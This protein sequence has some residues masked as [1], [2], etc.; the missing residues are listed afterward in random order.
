METRPTHRIGIMQGRL[1]P[2]VGDRV[3][4]FPGPLWPTEFTLAAELGYEAMELTI[5]N[6]SLET[7]PLLSPQGRRQIRDTAA[8]A[9]IHLAG[10]CCDTV[11]E[12]PLIGPD[13]HKRA[14]ALETTMALIRASAEAGLPMVELPMMGENSLRH[15][16]AYDR[17]A[18]VLDHLLPLADQLGILI[19][20]E[21]DVPPADIR[22]FLERVDHPRFGINYDSGNSTWFGY[23]PEDEIPVYAHW[24]G[25]VHVKDCTRKDYSVPLGSGETRLDD[26]FRLLLT[27]GYA[28]DFIL[29]AA[30]QADDVAAA[31][32]YLTV[33]RQTLTNARNS[34]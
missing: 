11:M 24:I 28:G 20:L 14:S 1:L 17:M 13:E 3:Q 22:R 6:A 16:G 32:D 12:T 23:E 18:A 10:L 27:A 8:A 26:V 30:R 4:A 29:Q 33:V 19:L 5:E 21:V 2:R 31:R 9:G 15:D 7:H 34:P 25:N